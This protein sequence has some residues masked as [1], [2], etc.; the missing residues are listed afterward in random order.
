M[1]FESYNFPEL[2]LIKLISPLTNTFKIKTP[3]LSLNR[4][5]KSMKIQKEDGITES[6]EEKI[7]KKIYTIEEQN[8]K[9][10]YNMN[11]YKNLPPSNILVYTD[12]ENDA[13]EL[14]LL[15]QPINYD[16]LT[17]IL[18]SD[19]SNIEN[20]FDEKNGVFLDK[21]NENHY[22]FKK[23]TYIPEPKNSN[24]AKIIFD[25]KFESGN[26]RMAIK[27]NSDIDNEY[28]LII[29]KDYNCEKNYSWF[30]FSI[31]C[32][33]ECDIKLNF[34]KKKIMFDEKEKIRILVYNEKDKWTRN[35]YNIQY[36]ENNI[37]ILASWEDKE[38][39]GS[40]DEENIFNDKFKEDEK[41][42]D[43]F[44]IFDKDKGEKEDVPDTE[45][46]FTLSF[47][48]LYLFHITRLFT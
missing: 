26:L 43:I 21:K 22:D 28:D 5:L 12:N 48:P 23:L 7:A 1:E 46:F 31:E 45:F 18:Q 37:K 27:L 10:L 36:Y 6:E 35:T 47:F 44:K 11:L 8:L 30:F 17:K 39:M 25:S 16:F 33:R 19:I 2:T 38:K 20:F 14:K 41:N 24:D 40:N 42:N 3:K 9:N 13:E 34:I 29:R 32:D 4:T 15:G